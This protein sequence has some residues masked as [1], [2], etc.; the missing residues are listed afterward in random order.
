MILFVYTS[1]LVLP[2]YVVK[3]KFPFWIIVS[4]HAEKMPPALAWSNQSHINMLRLITYLERHIYWAVTSVTS[5]HR[6]F[7]D[8]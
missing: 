8:H 2:Y 3:C 6:V 7:A 5:C 1:S 4:I